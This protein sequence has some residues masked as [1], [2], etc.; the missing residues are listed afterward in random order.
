MFTPQAQSAEIFK[1]KTADGR[2][3]FSSTG[4]GTEVGVVERPQL[5]FNDVGSFATA[6]EVDRWHSG[7]DPRARNS[8]S[9]ATEKKGEETFNEKAARM[10]YEM[11]ERAIGQ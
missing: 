8:R 2:T 6:E 1:C 5:K 7:R 10:R 3:I 9:P 4:C 11:I